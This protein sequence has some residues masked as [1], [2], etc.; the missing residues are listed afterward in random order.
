MNTRKADLIF[1]I[2]SIL[3][4]L[5]VI[6]FTG[7]LNIASFKKNFTESLVNTYAVSG[8]ETVR[9]IE[10]AVKYGKPLTN[11]YGIEDLLAKKHQ[12]HPDLTEVQIVL[13]DGKIQYTQNGAADQLF[14]E[15]DVGTQVVFEN[16]DDVPYLSIQSGGDYHVFLPLYDRNR[17]WI[18]S[19]DMVFSEDSVN[20]QTKGYFWQL[21]LYLTILA[22]FSL[23]CLVLYIFFVPILDSA[24]N[25]RKK[26]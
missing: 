5:V 9:K 19:L 12:D 24:G 11:F 26:A 18:G 15:P 17:D 10:Y 13:P 8:G 1:V 14:L 2:S 21:I 23:L 7:G 20:L 6:G 25:V 3:L 22:L 4:I 16:N